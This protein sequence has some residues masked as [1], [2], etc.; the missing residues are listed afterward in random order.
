MGEDLTRTV[1]R[2]HLEAWKRG[3]VPALLDDYAD[4]AVMLSSQAGVLSG[5]GAI[6]AMYGPVFEG[7]FPPADTDLEVT[8]EIVVGDH[9]LVHWTAKTSTIRTIG[10]FDAFTLRDGKIVAQSGGCEIVP[11]G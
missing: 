1:V 7:L 9:A 11:V 5:R 3:D 8:A 10:G 2:R 6:A 4:D